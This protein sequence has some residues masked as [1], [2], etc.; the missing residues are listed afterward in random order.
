MDKASAAQETRLL[1][2]DNEPTNVARFRDLFENS[3]MRVMADRFLAQRDPSSYADGLVGPQHFVVDVAGSEEAAIEL[4]RAAQQEER[5]YGVAIVG[6][7]APAWVDVLVQ[8]LAMDREIQ[9]IL[10]VSSEGLAW[11]TVLERLPALARYMILEKSSG[12][13]ATCLP[14]HTHCSRQI[15]RR[16]SIR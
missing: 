6:L 8:L 16:L 2:V 10:F 9:G 11:E 13:A 3:A 5:P 7:A 1:V 4:V 12:S 15:P 14:D